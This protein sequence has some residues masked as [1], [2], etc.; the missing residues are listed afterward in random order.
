MSSQLELLATSGVFFLGVF[1]SR[2]LMRPS[3][4]LT[5]HDFGLVA[6]VRILFG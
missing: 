5:I 2:F 1:T 3:M 6:L 4:A